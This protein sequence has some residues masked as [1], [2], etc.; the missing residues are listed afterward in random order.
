MLINAPTFGDLYLQEACV[1]FC[2]EHQNTLENN[3][4]VLILLDLQP[5]RLMIGANLLLSTITLADI[6]EW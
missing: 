5:L 3:V 6:A 4:Y 1:R 2:A